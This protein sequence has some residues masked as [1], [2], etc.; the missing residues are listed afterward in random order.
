MKLSKA[1]TLGAI[2]GFIKNSNIDYA[3]MCKKEREQL[4]RKVS[5]DI[6]DE[7]VKIHLEV[8]HANFDEIDLII[9]EIVK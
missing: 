8:Y 3:N 7:A 1:L 5:N 2:G 6:K 4:I 9:K